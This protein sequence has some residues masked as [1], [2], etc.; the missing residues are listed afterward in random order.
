MEKVRNVRRGSSVFSNAIK[1]RHIKKQSRLHNHKHKL[2]GV[3][4][5]GELRFSEKSRKEKVRSLSSVGIASSSFQMSCHVSEQQTR[6]P[7]STAIAATKRFK[8]HKNFLNDCNGASVPRKL[9][10]ATTKKRSRE[11]TLLDSEKVKHKMNG[12]ESLKNSVKKSKKQ[13]MRRDWSPREGVSGPITKDEE[14]VAETLYALAGMFPDNGSNHNGK[15][16]EGESLPDKSSVL[17]GMEDNASAALEATA[18]GGSP[19]CHESSPEEA[20][21]TSLHETVD[22]EQPDLP[23][24]ATVLMPSNSTSLTINLQVVPVVAKRE[25][26]NKVALHDTELCLA[27]GLNMPG[28][29]LIC[30][31]ERKLEFEAARDVDCKQQHMIKEQNGKEGLALSPG[32]SPVAPAGQ[33]YLQSSATNKAPDWLEAAI[34]ASNLDSMESSACSSSRKVSIPKR[35]WKKCAGHVHISHVI[36]SLE[37]SKRQVTIETDLF[38]CRQMKAHE[39]PKQGVIPE[40]HSLNEMKN[41]VT[42]STVGNPHEHKN[43]IL[44][45]QCHYGDLSQAAPTP[46][47]SGPQKQN[48]SFLSLSAANNGLKVDNNNYNKIGNRLEPLSKL[49][50]PYLQSL[51]QQHGAMQIPAAQSQYASTS[52]LDPLSVAGE[53]VRLQQHHYFGNPLCGTHTHYISTFPHKQEHQSFCGVQQAELGR[54]MLN[55]SVKRNQHPNWQSGRHDSSPSQEVFGSKITSISGQQKQLLATFQDKWTRPSS[56][57][58]M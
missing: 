39:G 42:S 32:L 20:S 36:K 16:T 31:V 37:V 38:E 10:S 3:F 1:R 6:E 27:M 58:C 47:V 8:V 5:R 9:R 54:P 11:S 41:G 43:I 55:F 2:L 13:G 48:F 52:F 15:Q 12:M 34:R 23:E 25:N 28:Q 7:S 30:N 22:Q 46:V 49:Q 18:Q 33:A 21:K 45:Q 26:S 53:P 57:F 14:E 51:S 35:S 44:Q 19:R 4:G 17:Q 50:V 24:S 56:P 40:V 29:L